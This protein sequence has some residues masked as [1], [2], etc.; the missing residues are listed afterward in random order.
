MQTQLNASPIVQ[1][2]VISVIH[3][4]LTSSLHSTDHNAML[5]H[6]AARLTY[7]ADAA[8]FQGKF[9]LEATITKTVAEILT[10][11]REI[12]TS[13]YASAFIARLTKTIRKIE[14]N[15]EDINFSR[16]SPFPI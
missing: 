8:Q 1:V 4:A 3:D 5:N 16:T 11:S 10:S 14:K 6:L 13:T 7:L 2:P 15:L 12:S 9:G